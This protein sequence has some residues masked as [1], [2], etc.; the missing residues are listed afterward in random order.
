MSGLSVALVVP[1]ASRRGGGDVWLA[2][3]LRV[4]TPSQVDLLVVFET[5]GELAN[6]AWGAGHRV[7][8]LGRNGPASDADLVGLVEPLARVLA[9]ARPRVTV[10][11]S[12]RAHV[13]GTRARQRARR[14]GPVAWVQ[15]VMPS[16]FW[17]H[18]LANS[19]PA[20]AVACVST[21]VADANRRL[22]PQR[23]AVVLH[24][25]VDVPA[26]P[27]GRA[28]ARASFDLP[29]DALVVGV[30]GRVE[31]WKGQ[32][33]MVR[34]VHVLREWALPVHALL[35][36][37]ERSS[38]WPTFASDLTA[39]IAGLGVEEHVSFTGHLDTLLGA[40]A[41]LDALVCASREE[42]FSLVV[43]EGMAA[44]IPVVATRCG[45]PEDLIDDGVSGFLVPSE[46]PA[47]LA[48]ALARL[49]QDR[50]LAARMAT[51]GQATWARRFTAEHGA[52]RLLT[53]VHELAGGS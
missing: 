26:T 10:H 18:R 52:R 21:A 31:P 49:V 24:P 34:A 50:P 23:R 7:A 39:L 37:D 46:Q 3:L 15:H 11:W 41:S 43:A 9:H 2:S 35:V 30:V 48:G 32:D 27:I 25:G 28:E 51:A 29:D 4:L 5:A 20:D 12:P 16:D 1:S 22:Y 47:A 33:I 14:A 17:L 8:V 38:T 6:L 36:G 42:G 40:L 53:F 45:G 13:Y 19:F 44:G